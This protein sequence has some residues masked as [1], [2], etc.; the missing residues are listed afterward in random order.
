MQPFTVGLVGKRWAEISLGRA[1][2]CLCCIAAGK[3][4]LTIDDR[5]DKHLADNW[6]DAKWIYDEAKRLTDGEEKE[7]KQD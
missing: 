2:S 7:P 1:D 6:E 4:V 3:G 5:H